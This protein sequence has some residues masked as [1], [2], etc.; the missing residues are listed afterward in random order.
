[1]R[2][3]QEKK[4]RNENPQFFGTYP[5]TNQTEEEKKYLLYPFDGLAIRNN[6]ALIQNGGYR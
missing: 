4:Y 1:L 2:W 6:P 5:H 3:V